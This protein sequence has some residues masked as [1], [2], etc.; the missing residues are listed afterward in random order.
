MNYFP[1]NKSGTD[2]FK[3]MHFISGIPARQKRIKFQEQ[4]SEYSPL[5]G[6]IPPLNIQYEQKPLPKI[7]VLLRTS[8]VGLARG[9]KNE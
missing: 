1:C 7:S 6:L 3:T 8:Q 2:R 4:I 9:G 5:K